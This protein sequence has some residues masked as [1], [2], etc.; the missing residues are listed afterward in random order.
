LIDARFCI[1]SRQGTKKNNDRDEKFLLSCR[2]PET[3]PSGDKVVNSV[4]NGSL[5]PNLATASD[6]DAKI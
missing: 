6:G 3:G 4:G 2:E 5:I 1:R